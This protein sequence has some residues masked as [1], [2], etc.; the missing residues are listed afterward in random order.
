MPITRSFAQ[1]LREVGLN[2]TN[3]LTE[4]TFSKND[5]SQTQ[6][7]PVSP[8]HVMAPPQV[9]P[10]PAVQQQSA[11]QPQDVLS[12]VDETHLQVTNQV[13]VPPQVIQSPREEPA[14]V[15]EVNK[16][17]SGTQASGTDFLVNQNYNW[18]NISGTVDQITPGVYPDNLTRV[19]PAKDTYF[20]TPKSGRSKTTG[21]ETVQPGTARTNLTQVY[22]DAVSGMDWLGNRSL[23]DSYSS[24]DNIEVSAEDNRR[25]YLEW[26]KTKGYPSDNRGV[27]PKTRNTHID[28]AASRPQSIPSRFPVPKSQVSSR[29]QPLKPVTTVTSIRHPSYI[30]P[31]V[32]TAPS[33]SVISDQITSSTYPVTSIAPLQPSMLPNPFVPPTVSA[34][35]LSSGPVVSNSS[36]PHLSPHP[37]SSYCGYPPTMPGYLSTMPGGPPTMPGYPPTMPGYPITIPYPPNMSGYPPV[38]PGYPPAMPGYPTTNSGYPPVTHDHHQTPILPSYPL[39]SYIPGYPQPKPVWSQHCPPPPVS[40]TKSIITS[41]GVHR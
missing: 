2:V 19:N 24:M 31:V 7:A 14:P 26:F 5:E 34:E 37:P 16:L 6:P 3:F 30:Q 23:H 41:T 8:Q 22:Q 1:A 32:T 15:S 4:G 27:I 13:T 28:N 38:M 39:Q 11:V 33:Q 10:P 40:S 36:L 18:E 25:R 29:S 9:A 12:N 20:V 21:A 35:P 17:R